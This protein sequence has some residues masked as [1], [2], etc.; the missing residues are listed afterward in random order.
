VVASGA[1]GDT[2]WAIAAV[3]CWV[4]GEKRHS[5][6][7]MRLLLWPLILVLANG[8]KLE[9]GGELYSF[10]IGIDGLMTTFNG[11]GTDDVGCAADYS[12]FCAEEKLDLCAKKGPQI[13]E[14]ACQVVETRRLVTAYELTDVCKGT[15]AIADGA[16]VKQMAAEVM[17]VPL[18]NGILKRKYLEVGSHLGCS[19]MLVALLTEDSGALVY[20]HDLWMENMEALPAEGLP[21]S[22]VAESFVKFYANIVAR[23]LEPRVIP[24]RGSS[25]YTLGAHEDASIAVAFV[26]GDHSYEGCLSDLRRVWPKVVPGG[27]VYVHDVDRYDSTMGVTRCV[28]DFQAELGQSHLGSFQGETTFV[29]FPR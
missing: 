25:N 3:G 2:G 26:D 28:V 17:A 23:G 6:I 10:P 18:P 15:L 29:R 1:V 20:A 13:A 21:P 4:V 16:I 9:D 22:T 11:T 14:F 12:R 5:S 8:E 27:A 7:F 19:A 24:M